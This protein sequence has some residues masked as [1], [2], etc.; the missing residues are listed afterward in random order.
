[1]RGC[2]FC[3]IVA[4]E[5][6]SYKVYEDERTLAFLDINPINP[7]HTLVIPKNPDV[8]NIFDIPKRDWVAMME[9]VHE[10]AAAVEKA[11]DA[12]GVNIMMNNREHAG[13]V[14][15]HPHIHIIPR[16]KGDGL[17][18]WPH[19]KY[20]PGEEGIMQKRIQQALAT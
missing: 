1:M 6:P 20:K 18:L 3:K 17:Q 4:G 5:L 9:V 7:G 8:R 12:D 2:I 19:K 13:Q 11:L 10:L 14:V 15:D 16:F